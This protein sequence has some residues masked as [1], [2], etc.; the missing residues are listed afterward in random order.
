VEHT[1]EHSQSEEDQG[2]A[3]KPAGQGWHI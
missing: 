3:E 2:G 1:Q